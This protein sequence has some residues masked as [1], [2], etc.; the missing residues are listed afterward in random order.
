MK[1]SLL[2]LDIYK[3]YLAV[4]SDLIV[5]LERNIEKKNNITDKKLK[6]KYRLFSRHANRLI[7]NLNIDLHML[8][9]VDTELDKL[10][11]I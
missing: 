4:T 8:I 5:I 7:N 1:D 9:S 11:E 6:A 2:L 10:E 3:R